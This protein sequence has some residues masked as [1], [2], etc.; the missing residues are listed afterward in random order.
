[1]DWPVTE[2]DVRVPR[3]VREDA[4]TP[5]ARVSPVSVPAAAV[6]VMSALPLKLVPLMFRAVC[7]VVAVE[8]LPVRVAVRAPVTPS[9]PPTLAFPE[10]T[11]AL[12][13]AV[14]ADIY[15]VLAYGKVEAVSALEV[16]VP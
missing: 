12:V 16:N 6:T 13:L 9:V 3:D 5:D 15:V 8:A 14:V 10:T 11:S 1:M 7:N 2:R 4:V